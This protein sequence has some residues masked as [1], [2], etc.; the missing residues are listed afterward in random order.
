MKDLRKESKHLL[1]EKAAGLALESR[2]K[3]FHC[4]ESVFLAINGALD[5]T[6]PGMVR[7]VTGFH[8]GGGAHRKEPVNLNAVLEEVASGRD[9][10][11]LE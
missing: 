2:H 11:S 10:R 4:S 1:V 6:D 8:G 9:R 7:A 5:I 3:G